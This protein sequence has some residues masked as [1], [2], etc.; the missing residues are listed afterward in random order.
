M[1]IPIFL[2]M[3]TGIIEFGVAFSVK[4]Q[5]TFA[6]RDAAIVLAESGAADPLTADCAILSRIDQDFLAPAKRSNIDHVDIFWAKA[7]GTVNNGAVETYK[8]TGTLGSSCPTL[9]WSRTS[10]LYPAQNRCSSITGSSLGLCQASPVHTGPDRI[11]VTIVY[12]YNW[13]TPLPG[14]V[15][16]SGSGMSF[17]QTNLTTI[18]PVPPST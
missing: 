5:V 18:E 1:I 16:L 2:A 12:Q 6:S 11:G 4:M 9:V 7:D 10:D 13:I 8:P 15:G 14:L 17:S 3:F